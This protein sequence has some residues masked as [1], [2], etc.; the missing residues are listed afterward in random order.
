M[1]ESEQLSIN[2]YDLMFESRLTRVETTLENFDKRFGHIDNRFGQIDKHMS[3]GFKELKSDIRWMFGIM[4]GGFAGI[5][6]L[7]AHGFHWF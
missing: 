1:T 4:L 5:F 6:G 3:E 7:M 2:K